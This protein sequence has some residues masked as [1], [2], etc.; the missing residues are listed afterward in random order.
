[1]AGRTAAQCTHPRHALPGPHLPE[2]CRGRSQGRLPQAMLTLDAHAKMSLMGRANFVW[3][4]TG[5]FR[6]MVHGEAPPSDEEWSRFMAETV[7]D[8]GGRLRAPDRKGAVIYSRGGMATARQRRELNRLEFTNGPP[9]VLVL[10]SDSAL[11]RGVATAL[12]WLLPSLKSY[13]VLSLHQLDEA[14]ALLSAHAGERAEFK[15]V[16]SKLLQEIDGNPTNPR[17]S[18]PP[19]SHGVRSERPSTRGAPR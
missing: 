15:Q 5:S 8:V 9:P 10:M 3:S 16:L 4:D 6:I 12:G 11:A 1:M 18:A 14:A 19:A 17:Q 13:H 7:R 2:D